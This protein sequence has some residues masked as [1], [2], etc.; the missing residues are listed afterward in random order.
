MYHL[1]NK[2]SYAIRGFVL[3]LNIPLH[4]VLLLL[5]QTN[6]NTALLACESSQYLEAVYRIHII[7]PVHKGS[8]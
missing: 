5:A 8:Q 2:I 6:F 4:M 3:L 7:K 1:T